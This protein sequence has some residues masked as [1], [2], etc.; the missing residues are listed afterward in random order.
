MAGHIFFMKD[1]TQKKFPSE[2]RY[3]IVSKDWVVIATGRAKRP[4]DFQETTKEVVQNVCPFD[5]LPY[6]DSFA[7]SIPNKYPAFSPV[8]S[9]QTRLVG[10]Y[11]VMDGVGFHEVLVTK[12][13]TRDIPDF[14]VEEVKELVDLY[15]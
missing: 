12:D 11:Q 3:D 7:I 5:D 8:Q 9:P 14:S 2:L 6:G 4:L 10:P 13:H 1:D 15:Q